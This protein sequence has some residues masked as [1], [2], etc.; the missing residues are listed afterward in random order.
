[1]RGGDL[2]G[3]DN[4]GHRELINGARVEVTFGGGAGESRVQADR[5]IEMGSDATHQLA[6]ALAEARL[7]TAT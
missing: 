5:P 1:M 2:F 7:V 6:F 4:G 3:E